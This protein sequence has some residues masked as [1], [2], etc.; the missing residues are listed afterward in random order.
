MS[1]NTSQLHAFVATAT[2]AARLAAREILRAAENRDMLEITDKAVNDFVTSADKAAEEIIIREL[3]TA[4][5]RHA[6]LSEEAGRTGDNSSDYLWIIDPI[7]G[8]TNFIH[9][10][11]QYCVSIGLTFRGEPIVGV[12]YDVAKNELF[13]AARGQGAKL[14]GRRIRVTENDEM[15]R[16]LI[17]T[18]FPFR[19]GCDIE[20]Y[21]K[22]FARVA[23][24]SAGIRRPGSAA[25]DLAWV[26]C[27]RYDGFW[28]FN[29]KPWDICA[30][31]LIVLEAGGLITDL[32]GGEKWLETGCICAGAPKIFAQLLPL[33]GE[34]A[35]HEDA[36]DAKKAEPRRKLSTKKN[37]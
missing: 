25:L 17:G 18:G 27:G 10:L 1:T 22:G 31:G 30:G 29:L 12:I 26:A 32:K 15:R 14:D 6:I 37:A 9:G 11:P 19:R 4:Y 8:T 20:S 24:R 13:T 28:E 23:E 21:L 5:P 35:H 33:V 16:A 2:K 34:V 3:S 36:D 7:D